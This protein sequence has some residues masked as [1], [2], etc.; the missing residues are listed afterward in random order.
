MP[1]AARADTPTQSLRFG[2]GGRFELRP[3]EYRL[4]VDGERAALGGR[5]LDLLIALGER[6]AQL[7]TKNEL[8]DIVWPGLV[9]EENNLRVQINTLR[10]LLGEDAIA[11]VPGRGYRLAVAIHAEPQALAPASPKPGESTEA[12]GPP[13]AKLA[14][15]QRLFGRDADLARLEGLLQAGGCVTLAGMP[16]VGKS[17]LARLALARWPGRSAWV[18]LAPL[19]Q[20]TQMVGAMPEP[21]ARSRTMATSPRN[22]CA[23][24]HKTSHCC[25]CWATPN[26]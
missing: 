23:F 18:D 15:P 20:G 6:P 2:L 5:A 19:T 16:G 17:S 10:R 9:V 21:W 13:V 12:R 22:C 4:L 7:L 1:S 11:T 24:C 14:A 3:A 25:W 26:T 8:L